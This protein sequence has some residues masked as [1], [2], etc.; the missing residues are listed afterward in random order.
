M[1]KKNITLNITP[2]EF[3]KNMRVLKKLTQRD[4]ADKMKVTPA[5]VSRFESNSLNITRKNL[6]IVAEGYNLSQQELKRL[7]GMIK[8]LPNYSPRLNKDNRPLDVF[9]KLMELSKEERN[10]ILK[11]AKLWESAK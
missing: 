6:N 2:G 8:C 4:V 7:E 11:M 9:Y 1:K 3:L 10:K 5:S